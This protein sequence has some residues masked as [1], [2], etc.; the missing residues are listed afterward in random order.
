MQLYVREVDGEVGRTVGRSS[1]VRHGKAKA[2][3]EDEITV[4]R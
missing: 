1:T 2:Q 4:I 3:D